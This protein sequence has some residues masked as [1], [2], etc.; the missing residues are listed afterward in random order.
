MSRCKDEGEKN[1]PK[2]WNESVPREGACFRH[3]RDRKRGLVNGSMQ[4]FRGDRAHDEC[5]LK[6]CSVVVEIISQQIGH[7]YQLFQ[8]GDTV[9]FSHESVISRIFSALSKKNTKC[10]M[11]WVLK[12]AIMPC[13]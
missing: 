8:G 9:P 1:D 6:A 13:R 7:F 3:E 12:T 2:S 4:N 10:R 11:R 5:L